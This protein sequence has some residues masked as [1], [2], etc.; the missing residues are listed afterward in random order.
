MANIYG[1]DF[2]EIPSNPS[3]STS[4]N[5]ANDIKFSI[6]QPGSAY[7]S[8]KNSYI[9]IGFQIVMTREDG[10]PHTLEPIVN[11]GPRTAPTHISIPY[12]APNPLAV[13]FQNI[14]CN[15]NNNELTNYQQ[16]GQTST[17][18]RYM[19][20]SESENR[21]CNSTNSI[22]PMSTDDTTPGAICNDSDLLFAKIGGV[23]GGGDANL[24]AFRKLFSKRM[25][26]ALK[27]LYNF[28]KY[29]TDKLN[30]QIPL[31][32]FFSND[33]IYVGSNGKLI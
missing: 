28:D 32:L 23:A 15:V 30:L 8:G 6:E 17:L 21:S 31:P 19:F 29:N 12:L 7:I 4:A 25:I 10:T 13:L 11:S 20:E 3:I 2:Y 27:N 33:L 14:S 9:S 5:F 22:L 24:I 26:Y 18:Y 1:H 16:V